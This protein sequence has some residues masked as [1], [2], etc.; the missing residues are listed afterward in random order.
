MF[1]SALRKTLP[2][3]CSTMILMPAG[4]AAAEMQFSAYGGIQRALD[5]DVDVSDQAD[6][7]AK[8]EGKSLTK[9]P[10]YWGIRGL[11][12]LDDFGYSNWGVSLDYT[13]AKVYATDGT[14]ASAAGDWTHFEFTDGLNLLTVNAIYRFTDFSPSWTPYVGV[15]AGINVPHVEVTR[16]SG[17]TFDYQ[18]GGA[19]F[20][21]QAGVD[22]KLTDK[23]SMFAEY[24]GNYSMIDVDIDNNAS[25]KTNIWTNAV[26]LGVTYH[27]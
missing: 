7:D 14:M 5:S 9:L 25:L 11:Y 23:W 13:H 18:F 3:L 10:P 24:K 8:W 6:F 12:W 20:Q 4:H 16:S 19:A 2:L 22:Y 1:S 17:S 21:V 15:G 26:N 27:W